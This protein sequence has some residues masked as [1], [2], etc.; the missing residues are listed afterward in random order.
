MEKDRKLP[1][2]NPKALIDQIVLLYLFLPLYII[3]SL[4][5]DPPSARFLTL[6]FKNRVSVY[7]GKF[8]AGDRDMYAIDL[9]ARLIKERDYEGF[10][11]ESGA[12]KKSY[13]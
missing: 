4:V 3:T 6:P 5:T 8:I 11:Y 10:D 1:I 9:L 12:K 13:G 7:L 2:K